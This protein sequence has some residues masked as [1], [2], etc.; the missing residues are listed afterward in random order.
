MDSKKI[1]NLTNRVAYFSVALL[2][3]WAFIFIVITVFDLKVFKENI[4]QAF[5]LSILGIFSLLSGAIILN[6]M[7]NMTRIS[8]CMEVKEGFS[9]SSKPA[10]R[11]IILIS[12]GLFPLITILLFMGDYASSIKKKESL[13]SAA[14]YLAIESEREIDLLIKYKFGEEYIETAS[15]V[16]KVLTK[17]EKKFPDI[18]VVVQDTIDG[19][20][21]FLSFGKWHSSD[22]EKIYKKEDHIFSASQED[23]EY[24]KKIYSGNEE[25]IKFGAHD[26]SYELYFPVVKNG[27]VIVLYLSDSQ[28]YGKFGS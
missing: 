21:V 6:I 13:V 25:K 8:E 7:L 16:L 27:S 10:K 24:L 14:E 17:V 5:Y 2:A 3:Y 26:G 9:S 18:R 19:R 11:K 22:D 1:V 20:E 28:R 23:R 15:D 4:T 12:L